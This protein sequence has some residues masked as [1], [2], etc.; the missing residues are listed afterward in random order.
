MS[1]RWLLT[2]AVTLTGCT[3]SDA[4]PRPTVASDTNARRSDAGA[5]RLQFSYSVELDPLPAGAGP[6]DVFI[7]LA[8]SDSHQRI[9]HSV[10]ASMPGVEGDELRYGNRFWHGHL[11]RSPGEPIEILVEYEVERTPFR[12]D[13]R[14]AG[15][16]REHT[17]GE[18]RQL[19]LFLGPNERVPVAGELVGRVRADLPIDASTPPLERARAIY[20]HVIDTM[21]YKKVGTGWG[22]G[23]TQWA[24][25]ERYGNCTDFHALLISLARAEG[26]PARFEIG[27]LVPDDREGEIAGYH[28]WVELHLGGIGWFPIDAAEAWKHPEDR[29]L[30]FGAQPADRLQLSVGRDLELGTGHETGRINYFVYPH[31]EVGGR[32]VTN[33]RTRFT[34]RQVRR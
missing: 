32:I 27:F 24:C 1:E 11:D 26:I 10:T 18:K 21:E 31:I 33:Y 23:D 13:R 6:V 22:N 9:Q 20:D 12:V 17:A 34:Y 19:S 8:R 7:P 5:R 2:L 3:A 25:S 30:Y 15:S 29:D 16:A 28:C 4:V 14:R